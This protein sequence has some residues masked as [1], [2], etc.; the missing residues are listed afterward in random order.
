MEF[1][2]Y[3]YR[4]HVGPDDNIQGSHTDIRPKDEIAD[5]RRKDPILNFETYLE[6]CA[7]VDGSTLA[8]IQE[9][10]REEVKAAH[11]FAKRSPHPRT[12]ELTRYVYQ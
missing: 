7:H 6:E 3:R 5:W 4:G 9:K 11:A 10:A 1:L 8:S 2:T 12:K